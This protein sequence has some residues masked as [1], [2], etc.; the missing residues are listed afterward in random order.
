MTKPSATIER[1]VVLGASSGIGRATT[2]ALAAR[3]TRVW[4]VARRAPALAEVAA[5]APPGTVETVVGDATDAATVERVLTAAA[6]DLIVVSVGILPP[7]APIDEVRWDDFAAVWHTDLKASFHVGQLTLR[8][9]LRRGSTVVLVS[10]GAGLGGSPQSGG[11]AGAKRMQMFLAGYLQQVADG[12]E[13]GVRYV[14]LVPR[15]LIAGTTIALT[16][17]TVYGGA[18]GPDAYMTRFPVPLDADGVAAAILRIAAGD[19]PPGPVLGLSG[20]TGLESI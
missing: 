20:G 7:M 11:Y 17:A 6:P 19:A 8:R 9:P 12:R 15:Q 5:S 18:A 2:L 13:L 1:A 3:G 16:A 14:A 4:A 10:S